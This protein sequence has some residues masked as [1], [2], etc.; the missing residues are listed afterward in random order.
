[1]QRSLLTCELKYVECFAQAQKE[2]KSLFDGVILAALEP[3]E[4]PK[5]EAL[6]GTLK[7]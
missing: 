3:P 5:K 2:L 6:F 4:P 7:R 1:M